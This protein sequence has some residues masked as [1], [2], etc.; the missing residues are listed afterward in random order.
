MPLAFEAV[1][2]LVISHLF[3]DYLLSLS[4]TLG[5]KLHESRVNKCF[6]CL[7]VCLITVSS[8]TSRVPGI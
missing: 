5:C 2:T 6:V 1:T 7:F 4:L 3:F 8:A